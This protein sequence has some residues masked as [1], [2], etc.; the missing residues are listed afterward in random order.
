[1]FDCCYITVFSFVTAQIVSAEL[2]ENEEKEIGSLMKR[3]PSLVIMG[4]SNYAKAHVANEIMQRN[5]LPTHDCKERWR[6]AVFRYGTSDSLSLQ[7]PDSYELVDERIMKGREWKTVPI[8]DLV[9]TDED[10]ANDGALEKAVLEINL[11][12]NLLKEG[13]ILSVVQAFHSQHS[14]EH[15]QDVFTKF[16]SEVIPVVIYTV[17]SKLLSQ[18]VSFVI[19]LKRNFYNY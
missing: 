12:H 19:W 3:V 2:S 11:R 16:T 13:G 1:M 18:Q 6:S 15:I 9:L 17:S 8:E 10:I 4:Q 5:I 14:R 7:L